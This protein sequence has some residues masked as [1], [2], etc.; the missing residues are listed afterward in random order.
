MLMYISA[1]YVK[2]QYRTLLIELEEEKFD[3]LDFL[4]HLTSGFKS[5]F[6]QQ[7]A[8]NILIARQSIGGA[9]YTDWSGMKTPYDFGS[10]SV[11]F[12]GD[13]TVMGIQST[14]YLKK[15]YK[16][17]KKG[18]KIDHE[19]LGYLNNIDQT[20]AQKCTAT[21][22]EDFINL[23]PRGPLRLALQV[24]SCYLVKST[25]EK[26]EKHPASNKEKEN[27]IFA[28]EMFRMAYTHLR[29][30]SVLIFLM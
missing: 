27:F 10:P 3:R 20:L 9:G 16:Q 14:N 6:T 11:T 24:Q 30:L 17:I 13:N 8:D 25:F 7:A 15:L 22:G 21:K 2:E 28:D 19:L 29:H 12:E 18:Q 4:H 1:R 5:L 23:D 26:M